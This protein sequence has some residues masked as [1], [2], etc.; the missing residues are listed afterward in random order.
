MRKCGMNTGNAERLAYPEF[1]RGWV[2]WGGGGGGVG[3]QVNIWCP[4]LRQ[5]RVWGSAVI[6]VWGGAPE[7]S[8]FGMKN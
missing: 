6:R 1:R 7:A 8:C 4:H 3:A 2:G 5:M